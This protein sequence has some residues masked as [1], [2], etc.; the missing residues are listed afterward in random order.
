M[1]ILELFSGTHSIGKIG[2]KL[3]HEIVSLDRDL[4]AENDGYKSDYHIKADIMTWDYK[5]EFSEGDFD[6]ITAS[7]VCLFWSNLRNTWIGRRSKTI[8]SDGS[9]VT[10]EDIERDINL[11]GKPM[12]DKCFEIIEFFKPKY[13]WLENP[14][15][16]RMKNYISSDYPNYNTY[17][18][19][20]YC[21]Y[22]DWGYKKKTRFWTNIQGF[23]PKVCK[24]DCE[25]YKQYKK[26]PAWPGGGS[27]RLPRYRIPEPL[28]FDL[29]NVL[30]LA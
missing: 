20:D 22:S 18:D 7:P 21:K 10:R 5:N 8:N 6:L 26:H 1:R 9:I 13:W 14:A 25:T 19:V 16:G 2:S 17:F 24:R 4:D 3:G 12:V 11:H 28:I 29:L 23:N 30:L 15:T 27:N